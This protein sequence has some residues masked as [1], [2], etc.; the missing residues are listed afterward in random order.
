M[1]TQNIHA[2]LYHC[3]PFLCPVIHWKPFDLR[4]SVLYEISSI[5]YIKWYVNNKDYRTFPTFIL[6]RHSAGSF[7]LS[8]SHC[9]LLVFQRTYVQRLVLFALRFYRRYITFTVSLWVE[10]CARA[11]IYVCDVREGNLGYVWFTRDRHF[12]WCRETWMPCCHGKKM[13]CIILS[14]L[15]SKILSVSYRWRKVNLFSATS[16]NWY[17]HV[18]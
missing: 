5:Q 2:F 12:S 7:Y 6:I 13:C 15:K 8:V 1:C 18:E 3:E 4:K 9:V 16:W 14:R 17:V 11:I 10:C